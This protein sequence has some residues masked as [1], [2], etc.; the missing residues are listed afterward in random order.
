VYPSDLIASMY[1]LL[2]IDPE[3]TL[4]HPQGM[5]VRLTPSVAEG[6]TSSGRLEEIM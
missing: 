1:E 2:G 6:V 3:T 5:E 4:R